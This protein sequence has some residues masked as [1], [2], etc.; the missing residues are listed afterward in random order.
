M[1]LYQH[2]YEFEKIINFQWRHYY[3][4]TLQ[5]DPYRCCKIAF[6]LQPITIFNGHTLR[7][8]IWFKCDTEGRIQ[9]VKLLVWTG[10]EPSAVRTV[11][12][13]RRLF[14]KQIFSLK[15]GIPSSNYGRACRKL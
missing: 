10:N 3:E 6:E 12:I 15:T 7:M 13:F 5:S 4:A 11:L 2:V 14:T 1:I 9:E 8:N